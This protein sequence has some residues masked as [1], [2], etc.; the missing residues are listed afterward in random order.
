LRKICFTVLF[1]LYCIQSFSQITFNIN[2][3]NPQYPFP[4]FLGYTGASNTLA[5]NNP[6]GVPHAEQ[7]QRTRDAYQILTN[8]LTY[9]ILKGGATSTV[10]V[11]TTKYIMPNKTL[12]GTICGCAEGDG[13]NMLAAAYMADKAT[14]D[15]YYMW[16]HDRQF[17]KTARYIDGVVNSP[18]Y[19]YSP[20]ISGAG[21]STSLDV[22]G[23][24]LSGNSPG[25]GDEDIAM[26]LLVAWK[27]W[28]DNG[29]I[30]GTGTTDFSGNPIYYKTE[31]I[32]YIKTM[33]DTV[34]FSISYPTLEY[35]VGDIGLDGYQK[36]GDSWGEET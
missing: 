13:Y 3:G 16:M 9:N 4:Q 18:T 26:A 34:R 29:R 8:N 21:N 28:G 6:V 19:A 30:G 7:E 27:Q 35:V 14:F 23:G 36:G 11:G 20:G 15:G 5:N 1:I 33:V 24:G 22:L 31:A 25:D 12:N 17:Q 10:T 2:S 32:K